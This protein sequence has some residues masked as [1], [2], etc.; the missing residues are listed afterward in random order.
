MSR[1]Q[2]TKDDASFYEPILNIIIYYL[3]QQPDHD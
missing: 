3:T 2:L 1:K